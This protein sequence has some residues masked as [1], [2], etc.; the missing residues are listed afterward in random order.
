M[1]LT[2]SSYELRQEHGGVDKT[3]Y[4]RSLEYCRGKIIEAVYRQAEDRGVQGRLEWRQ[5]QSAA[6]DG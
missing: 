4:Q 5:I 6:M 2:I 1:A 3:N